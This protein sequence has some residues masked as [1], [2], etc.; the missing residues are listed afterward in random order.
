[1]R[2]GVLDVG[3]NTVHLLVVDAHPGARPTAAHSHKVELRLLEHLEPD[4]SLQGEC[5]KR[6]SDTVAQALEI[7]EDKGVEDMLAFATSALRE[8]TNGEE[9]LGS[10]RERTG[11][12]LE[13]LPGVDE[14]RLTFLAVRRWY[15]WSAG[16]L[17]VV[18]IGGGSLELACGIDEEPDVAISLPLGASRLTR[19]GFT[20]DPPEA[21]EVKALRKSVRAE[22]A[23]D[24]GSIMRF[25][26]A[27]FAVATSKTLK[28][29]ARIAGAA[30][31]SEGPYV[32]RSLAHTDVV[33]WLTKMSEM[34]SAERARLPGVSS[35]R[36]RQLLAGAIVAD[37]AM[38]LF[39]IHELE[40]C[41]WAL[42]EGLILRRLDLLLDTVRAEETFG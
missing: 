16:R 33:D 17:L 2:L 40:I 25:G 12:A 13:V 9:V 20:T 35:G 24:V 26:P 18:D 1:M 31:S 22:I 8:A 42:R 27:D 37:A 34:S 7:A 38:S 11:I 5:V 10:I 23:R 30:P 21:G 41:P 28:Q 15:G 36:A 4:G 29:L 32:R 6:L 14:A 39:G 19:S 3:S